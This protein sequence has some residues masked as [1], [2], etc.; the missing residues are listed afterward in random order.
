MSMQSALADLVMQSIVQRID[1]L[2]EELPPDKCNSLKA[3]N[4]RVAHLFG[5]YLAL[6]EQTENSKESEAAE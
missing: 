1:A 2:A 3:L 6:I 5:G 4:D